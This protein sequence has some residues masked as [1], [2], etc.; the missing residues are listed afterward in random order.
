VQAWL[1]AEEGEF[2]RALVL[3]AVSVVLG[4]VAAMGAITSAELSATTLDDSEAEPVLCGIGGCW[5]V[6]SN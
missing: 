6:R 1:F 2:L 5:P 4:V 3:L